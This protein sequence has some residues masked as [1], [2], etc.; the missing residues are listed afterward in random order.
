VIIVLVEIFFHLSYPEV[1]YSPRTLST[2]SPGEYH[3]SLLKDNA[4]VGDYTFRIYE[5]GQFRGVKAYFSD[6]STHIVYKNRTIDIDSY[7]VFD[8]RLKPLEYKLNITLEGLLYTLLCNFSEGSVNASYK[9]QN[10]SG[11]RDVE[12][13]K[14]TILLDIN[15][16]GHWDLFFKSFDMAPNRRY[17]FTAFVPQALDKV[18]MEIFVAAET[19]TIE[20]GG[21]KYDCKVVKGT[22]QNFVYYIYGG[23]VL[24]F[25]DLDQNV[26]MN[27]VK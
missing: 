1:S 14:N 23:Q 18:S 4:T 27:L 20:I 2:L 16:V 13:P 12:L 11:V 17:S 19:K 6:S 15:M 7:Y 9:T 10:E 3:Y 8:E 21:V 26:V 25:E 5:T 22:E 24:R